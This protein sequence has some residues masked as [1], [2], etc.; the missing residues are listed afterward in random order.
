MGRIVLQA[1]DITKHFISGKSKIDVLKSINFSV[2]AGDSIAIVGK[3]G[4]GKSTLLQICG[5]LDKPS[6]GSI[7]IC[8]INSKDCNDVELTNIRRK[9]VG[10]IYQFHHL[11][12]EFSV[13]EN[14]MIP[15]LINGVSKKGS[16][17]VS[18][19]Y[20]EMIN[21]QH[22]AASQISELSG[23]E[24]QRISI[25]RGLINSPELVLADEPT[26]SLDE[27]NAKMVFDCFFAILQKQ[28]TSMVIV[29]HNIELAKR[30]TRIME[31]EDG[32]VIE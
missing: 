6:Q 12:P 16:R 9:K 1:H 31:L 27:S 15:Q 30:C 20:L 23:G 14:L 19:E 7:S 5:L 32:N 26:G 10:F 18:M 25:L 29:T 13:L 17:R 3:S 21:M 24:Q 11:L 8:D 4:S 28:N 22:R 2:Y